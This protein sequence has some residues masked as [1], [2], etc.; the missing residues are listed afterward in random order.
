MNSADLRQLANVLQDAANHSNLDHGVLKAIADAF[1]RA[2]NDKG[3]HERR[4][5]FRECIGGDPDHTPE[6]YMR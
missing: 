4:S 2:A 6:E 1:R 3:E 5:D